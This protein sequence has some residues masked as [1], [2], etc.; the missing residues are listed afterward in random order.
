MEC[1]P[2]RCRVALTAPETALEV[3]DISWAPVAGYFDAWMATTIKR[4]LGRAW[5]PI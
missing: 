4:L 1:T 2:G 3:E 5:L